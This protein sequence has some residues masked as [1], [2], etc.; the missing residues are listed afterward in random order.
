MVLPSL[1][2]RRVGQTANCA[3][4]ARRASRPHRLG[5]QSNK[6]RSGPFGPNRAQCRSLCGE[7]LALLIIAA[8][9]ERAAGRADVGLIIL[10]TGEDLGVIGNFGAAEAKRVA[11]AILLLH[12]KILVL[13]EG[14]G[15]H[16]SQQDE[17]RGERLKVILR[18]LFFPTVFGG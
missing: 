7:R 3:K 17:G 13:G 14:A 15:R 11:L 2:L 5:A 8:R 16:A 4:C 9:D 12:L 1:M 6:K 10:E 18:M